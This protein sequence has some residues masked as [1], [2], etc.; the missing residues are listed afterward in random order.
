MTSLHAFGKLEH[1]VDLNM[2]GCPTNVGNN[3]DIFRSS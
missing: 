1:M 2:H 3:A